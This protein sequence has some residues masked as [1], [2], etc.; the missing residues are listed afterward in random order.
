MKKREHTTWGGNR[1]GL[2]LANL[3]GAS[4]LSEQILPRD[5]IDKTAV[6]LVASQ[7]Q[8]IIEEMK[9]EWDVDPGSPELGR[10]FDLL[11]HYA[12]CLKT[13]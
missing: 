6:R 8:G 2:R 5:L 7:L 9:R 13:Y 11:F 1:G 3:A 12:R 10:S 4:V